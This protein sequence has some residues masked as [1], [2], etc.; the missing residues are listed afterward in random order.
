[1]PRVQRKRNPVNLTGSSFTRSLP[2]APQIPPAN[3]NTVAAALNPVVFSVPFTPATNPTTEFHK[4]F[5]EDN[6]TPQKELTLDDVAPV[7]MP[8]CGHGVRITTDEYSFQKLYKRKFH[9]RI[10]G[11][12]IFL[13][14]SFECIQCFPV[15]IH[16]LE[17]SPK[18]IDSG[19][20]FSGKCPACVGKITS[21]KNLESYLKKQKLTESWGMSLTD[22]EFVTSYGLRITKSALNLVRVGGSKEVEQT[23][24]DYVSVVEDGVN[25]EVVAV[26]N[27]TPERLGYGPSDNYDFDGVKTDDLGDPL[28]FTPSETIKAFET[29][30]TQETKEALDNPD[31]IEHDTR[32]V[33][34]TIETPAVPEDA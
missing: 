2:K 7:A 3:P 8:K 23:D 9:L 26:Q 34:S 1:M 24:A 32:D 22:G 13:P 12:T 15:C 14:K 20:R 31:K 29:A 21:A 5:G 17:L 25:D 33:L 4:L 11:E 19:K 27:K 6:P 30:R 28:M 18:E 16:G 10:Y